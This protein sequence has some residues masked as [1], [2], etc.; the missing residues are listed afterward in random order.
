MLVFQGTAICSRL[1]I[2]EKNTGKL[3]LRYFSD[4]SVCDNRQVNEQL[5]ILLVL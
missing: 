5:K 1:C 4:L 2:E 3:I